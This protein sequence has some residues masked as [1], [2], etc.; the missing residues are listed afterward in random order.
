LPDLLPTL[1]ASLKCN[2]QQKSSVTVDG[3]P[4][5]EGD[6]LITVLKGLLPTL[7]ASRYGS[8]QNGQRPDGSAFAGAKKPSLERM[9][10]TLR[11]SDWTKHNTGKSAS[12]GPN[13]REMLPTLTARDHRTGNASPETM[14]RNA[15]P[16]SETL[17][18]SRPGSG[19]LLDPGF[20]EAF[21]GFPPGWTE[22]VEVAGPPPVYV[23]PASGASGTASSRR[24]AKSSGG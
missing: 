5:S 12:G 16:L 22:P 6:G 2:F 9:L 19:C 11:A 3:R 10:P 20:A 17:G 24:S 18:S 13:L 8:S 23:R 15:R 14:T 4:S 7:T 21:M 1:C